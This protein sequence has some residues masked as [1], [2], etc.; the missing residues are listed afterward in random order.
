METERLWHYEAAHVAATLVRMGQVSQAS[1]VHY[2]EQVALLP[3]MTDTPSHA[4]TATAT[5][6]LGIHFGLSVYDA[7][8]L[9]L[10]LRVGGTLA[11]NDKRLRTATRRAGASMFE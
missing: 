3:I 9:E 4:H 7:A 6:T 11:T 5:F 10:V 1:A 8:Y 2:F